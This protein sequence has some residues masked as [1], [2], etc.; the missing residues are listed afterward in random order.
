MTRSAPGD[1]ELVRAFVNTRDLE[2]ASDALAEPAGLSAW[3]VEHRLL[4]SP[5]RAREADRRHAVAVREAL[6][7]VLLAHHGSQVPAEATEQLDAAAVRARLALRFT[8][9]GDAVLVP[10]APGVQ[11]A[12]GRLLSIVASAQAD[13]TWARLKACPADDCLWAFYDASRNRSARWC[14]MD[15]CGNRA[16]VRRYRERRR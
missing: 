3:L 7:A 10:E 11:G 8:A 12:L 2:H 1:L 13:G 16:K 9:D 14:T 15:E 4:D 6:R 5:G